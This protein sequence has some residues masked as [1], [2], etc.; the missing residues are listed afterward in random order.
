[1]VLASCRDG[2]SQLEQWAL[3]EGSKG[4]MQ[5]GPGMNYVAL[6]RSTVE[7]DAYDILIYVLLS[8]LYHP[9]SSAHLYRAHWEGRDPLKIHSFQEK[10]LTLEFGLLIYFGPQNT[11]TARPK[12]SPPVLNGM[13]ETGSPVRSRPLPLELMPRSPTKL[14]RLEANDV[15]CGSSGR[16]VR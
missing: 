14:P 15:F 13:Y 10:A 7:E 6:H 9:I 4:P 5:D 8:H 3:L 12:T 2:Y 11:S 1:M 16:L